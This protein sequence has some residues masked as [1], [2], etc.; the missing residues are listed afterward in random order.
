MGLNDKAK[1]FIDSVKATPEF[2]EL[3]QSRSVIEKNR[4]L[5]NRVDDFSKH[6]MELYASKI[7]PREV[8]ARMAELNKKFEDLSKIPEV[9]KFLKASKQF[10]DMMSKVYKSMNDSLEAELKFR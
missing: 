6:Q 1:E 7:S 8:E 2:A 9:D 4:V 3:R 10:N 5:K